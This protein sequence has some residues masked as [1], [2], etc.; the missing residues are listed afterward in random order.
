MTRIVAVVSQ[1]GGVGKTSLVQNLGA[2][3]AQ[4]GV[5]T[6]LIDFDPQSNLTTGWGIDP[7]EER[8]TI[9]DA[10][11]DPD[12]SPQAIIGLRENLAIM[13]ANLDLAGAELAFINAIDRNNKLRK[14]LQPIVAHFDTILIDGPPSLGFFTVNALAA[15]NEILIPLQVHP[16]A[17]KAID[18]LL[19][20][21]EQV[22]EINPELKLS[23]ITLTMHD[24]RNSLTSAIEDA[25]RSRFDGLVFDTVIPINVRIAEATLDGVSVGEYEASSSGAQAYKNL[26]KEVIGHGT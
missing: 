6:L 26:A 7:Y 20:I 10:M 9:Y 5:R 11:V 4:A 21:V 8:T 2:E 17:Y 16:Y 15:A 12:T 22:Q 13:P 3:I 18:Q 25:A 14:A 19:G 1:K 24:R 23:G